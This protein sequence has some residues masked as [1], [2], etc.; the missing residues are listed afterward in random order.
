M[1]A[2][3]NKNTEPEKLGLHP[4][5]PHRFRYDFK[6]LISVCPELASFVFVNKFNIESIDFVDYQAVK[7]L[8]KALLK[9]FYGIEN[10]DLPENYLCPPIP[11]RAD[12]IHYIADLLASDNDGI[13]PQGESVRVLDI[14]VGANGVYPIIGHKEYGWSFVGSDIDTV[15]LDN[16]EDIVRSNPILENAVECRLQESRLAIF[17]DII[18]EAEVFDVSIC[19][20]PFHGSLQEAK[21][22]TK[23][24]WKNLGYKKSVNSTLNFGGQNA[25]ICTK[26]GEEGFVTRMISESVDFSKNVRWFTTLISKSENLPAVYKAIRMA[27]ARDVKTIAMAQGQK[28]SRVVAWTFF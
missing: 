12:Y 14:G 10:W 4:R 19:N 13:I 7:M 15:A 5:N 1:E 9:Q 21:A 17:D 2:T 22:G 16:V 20:P 18:E 28:V 8:N 27:G 23:R 6:Q 26:G 3:R 11:G 25:E 24:K